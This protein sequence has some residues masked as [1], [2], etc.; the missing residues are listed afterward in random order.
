MRA[1]NHTDAE[2]EPTWKPVEFPQRDWSHCSAAW[3]G[4]AAGFGAFGRH[5]PPRFPLPRCLETQAFPSESEV[6][7]VERNNSCDGLKG[8]QEDWKWA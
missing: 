5:L 4:G 3:Q 7:V 6:N 2:S 1:L 8:W